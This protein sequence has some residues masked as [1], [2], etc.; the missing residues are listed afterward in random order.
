MSVM[1]EQIRKSFKEGDD[2]RDAGLQ[3]PSD[4]IRYDDIQYGPDKDW[5][6]MDLY[7]PR[8]AEGAVLPVIF[9]I[10][11]GGWVY[12]DKER[13]QYYCMSLAQRGFA[14]LNFTYRLAPE[15]RYPAPLEDACLVVTWMV[16][17]AAKYGL[18]TK[19]VFAVGDSAG[20]HLLG[21]FAAIKTNPAYAAEYDFRLP[22]FDLRAI[23]LNCGTFTPGRDAD[24][25][26]S[27]LMKDWLPGKDYDAEIAKINV[28]THITPDF[29]PVFV[30]SAVDDFLKHDAH[31][32]AGVLIENEVP[33][34][35]RIYGD[36]NVRLAH[37]FHCNMKTA[38]GK[39]CNDDECAFFREFLG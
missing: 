31:R 27:G 4:V 15:F 25:E 20:G 33:F 18:D 14:V 10:H 1:S 22:D 12:G 2:I 29:P 16:E 36:K 23:A 38:E 17:N 9:S 34:V 3:T 13:Y 39:K 19:R 7:R 26:V 28:L 37:V 11:G 35:L 32:I 24:G 21:L 5:Q 6:V 8:F 30:M